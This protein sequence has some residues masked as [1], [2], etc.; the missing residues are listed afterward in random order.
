MKYTLLPVLIEAKD[1]YKILIS[2]S[3]LADYP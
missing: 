2:E 1:N 3:D